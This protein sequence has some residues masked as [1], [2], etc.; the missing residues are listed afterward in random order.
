MSYVPLPVP[1]PIQDFSFYVQETGMVNSV[2]GKI[3]NV[4]GFRTQWSSTTAQGDIC[5][6]LAGGQDRMN[7]PNSATTYYL[8]STSAQ[9]APGGT[10]V[11][12]VRILYLDSSGVENV[13]TVALNG[14]TPVVLGSGFSFVQWMQAYHSTVPDRVT[15]GDIAMSSTNGAATEATTVELIQ[16]GA[17][18]SSSCRYQIPSNCQGYVIDYSTEAN[19]TSGTAKFLASIF[20]DDGAL[21]NTFT[22]FDQAT[23]KDGTTH[24]SDLH[25]MRLPPLAMVKATAIPAQL[26]VGNKFTAAIHL[27]ITGITP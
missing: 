21:C 11:D 1:L 4:M 20:A 5:A 14:T 23:L 17:N 10:G 9:D 22:F 2:A 24:F 25:Y 6:Y 18:R 16:A 3:V 8:V 26:P 27:L 19:G 12:T 13:R 7:I 15:V